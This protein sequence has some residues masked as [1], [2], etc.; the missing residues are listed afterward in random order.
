M[1]LSLHDFGVGSQKSTSWGEEG[2]AVVG[3][4]LTSLA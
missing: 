1:A 4:N 3:A 2:T